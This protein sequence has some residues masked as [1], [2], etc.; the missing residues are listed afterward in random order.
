MA[1][2]FA[3]DAVLEDLRKGIGL[4]LTS[5][6]LRSSL[7]IIRCVR[8]MLKDLWVSRRQTHWYVKNLGA[9]YA[10]MNEFVVEDQI[11]G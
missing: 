8:S 6:A 11:D 1:S 7:A 4:T 9:D 2:N 3:G 5:M 10:A